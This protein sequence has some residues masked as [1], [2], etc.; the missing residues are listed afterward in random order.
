MEQF[1]DSVQNKC[2]C[3]G[4][5]MV[6]LKQYILPGAKVKEQYMIATGI[7]LTGWSVL[8]LPGEAQRCF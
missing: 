8:D 3:V 7:S 4:S 6:D 2:V 1:H 5:R